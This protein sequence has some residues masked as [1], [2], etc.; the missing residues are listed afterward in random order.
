MQVITYY[1]SSS[2]YAYSMPGTTLGLVEG[3]KWEQISTLRDLTCE[4][5]GKSK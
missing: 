2:K 4:E 3:K 5:E 1:Y